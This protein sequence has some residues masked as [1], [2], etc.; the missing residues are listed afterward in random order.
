MR[1]VQDSAGWGLVQSA[2]VSKGAAAPL[3]YNRVQGGSPGGV[4]GSAPREKFW[5]I[6]C[7]NGVVFMSIRALFQL[8]IHTIR[9]QHTTHL[10]PRIIR[11]NTTYTLSYTLA[12][13][14]RPPKDVDIS[15]CTCMV[16][17]GIK[18][19]TFILHS[20]PQNDCHRGLAS[21]TARLLA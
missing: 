4:R 19:A 10:Q 16:V 17:S 13:V 12:Q 15:S 20:I 2:G 3:A 14:S 18:V 8:S 9:A 7:P 11:A 1:H 5:P 21:C 6:R